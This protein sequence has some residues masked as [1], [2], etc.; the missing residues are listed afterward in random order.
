M[1]KFGLIG[2]LL[3]FTA[4]VLTLLFSVNFPQFKERKLFP[5]G[6]STRPIDLPFGPHGF[7]LTLEPSNKSNYY[8]EV[9]AGPYYGNLPVDFDLWVVNDTSGFG[10]LID[11][12]NV[13]ALEYNYPDQ[14][15]FTLIKTYAKEINITSPRRFRLENLDRNGKYCFVLVNFYENFTQKIRVE[16]MEHYE[17]PPK[18]II[19]QTTTIKISTFLT[20]VTGVIL[21]FHA[22]IAKKRRRYAKRKR[23]R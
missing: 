16:V 19:P 17:E 6:A 21:V 22:E 8:V 23:K 9:E 2:L 4:L 5:P 12:L 3:I 14:Y 20:A 18:P 13:E 7:N 1:K 15:P 10:L 11:F